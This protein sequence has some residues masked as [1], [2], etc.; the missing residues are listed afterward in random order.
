MAL[1]GE[2]SRP[3]STGDTHFMGRESEHVQETAIVNIPIF[4]LY[5]N[6]P[7]VHPKGV[8]YLVVLSQGVEQ[9]E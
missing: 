1:F 2:L 8:V 9:H 7:C 4:G 3:S 5:S 6:A